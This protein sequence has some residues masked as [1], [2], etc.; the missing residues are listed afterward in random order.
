MRTPLAA[1]TLAALGSVAWP[2]AG[3][4]QTVEPAAPH[5][6]GRVLTA[7]TGPVGQT[8]LA[9]S[10]YAYTGAVLGD[11]DAHHRLA[12][13][14][15]LDDRV[16]SWLDLSL[17]LDGRADVHTVPGQ[18]TGTDLVGDPRLFVRVDR[19]WANGLRLGARMG[20][21]L[22]GRNAPSVD[23]GAVSPELVGVVSYVA[24]SAPVAVTANLGYR[25]D[26][27]AHSAP[28]AAMLEPRYR[29]ALEVSAFDEVLAGVA[30]TVGRG[31]TQGFVEASADL[32]VGAGAPAVT[33][34]PMLVGGGARFAV[35]PALQLEANLEVSPSRRPDVGPSAPL[36]P[37]P[38][39]AGGWLGLVY[40]FGVSPPV[41]A[42]APAAPAPVTPAPLPVTAPPPPPAV[43]PAE[44]DEAPAADDAKPAPGGQIR[45]VV[46]SLRGQALTADVTV[47]PESAALADAQAGTTPAATETKR[48]RAESGRFR[49]DVQPGRYRVTIEAPGYTKQVRRVD[50][51]DNGVTLLNV[52]LRTER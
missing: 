25:L 43:P 13:S 12:G 7:G 15:A 14:L 30:V 5:A 22:P 1:T 34:S 49:V 23:T 17:R 44:H 40:R 21:W 37:I 19:D 27:S 51:E 52:D 9:S 2:T 11:G 42:A 36:V 32:L 20:L 10:G 46:R 28:D 47:E 50:V 3:W 18:S 31:R 41:Q 29:V 4:A 35:T 24:P 16:L 26:R 38:P 6:L 39:R 8:V 48:I 33:V 45:G